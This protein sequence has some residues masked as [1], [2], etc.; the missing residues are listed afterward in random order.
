VSLPST[1]EGDAEYEFRIRYILLGSENFSNVK[2]K[3][4]Q[5]NKN[6]IIN[7]L[8]IYGNQ[9]IFKPYIETGILELRIAKPY[10][11]SFKENYTSYERF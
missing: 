10:E 3:M 8:T 5:I 9:E 1:L 11:N 7:N 2:N 6:D 4:Y